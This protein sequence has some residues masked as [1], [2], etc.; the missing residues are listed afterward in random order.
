MTI[1]SSNKNGYDIVN[2]ASSLVANSNFYEF[3]FQKEKIILKNESNDR[4]F[5]SGQDPML[6]AISLHFLT[7]LLLVPKTIQRQSTAN[8][9]YK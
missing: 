7:S 2:E 9:I 3:K 6:K 4:K 8:A 5:W 1:E